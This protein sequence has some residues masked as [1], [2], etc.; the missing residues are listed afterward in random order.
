MNLNTNWPIIVKKIIECF[1]SGNGRF[2]KFKFPVRSNFSTAT[3]YASLI[4]NYVICELRASFI[5]KGKKYNTRIA[6]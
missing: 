5:K 2:S 4:Y 1:L 3:V 6:V